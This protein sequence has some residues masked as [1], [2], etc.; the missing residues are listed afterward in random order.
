MQPPETFR[1]QGIS[2]NTQKKMEDE[3]GLK[4][5]GEEDLEFFCKAI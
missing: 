5:T 3:E 2:L 1:H 4:K